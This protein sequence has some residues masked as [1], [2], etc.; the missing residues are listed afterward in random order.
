MWCRSIHGTRAHSTNPVSFDNECVVKLE[1]AYPTCCFTPCSFRSTVQCG[2]NFLLVCRRM[3]IGAD[4]GP[5]FTCCS[6]FGGNITHFLR[7][8]AQSTVQ[9]LLLNSNMHSYILFHPRCSEHACCSEH[10]LLMERRSCRSNVHVW[11]GLCHLWRK[12]HRTPS[13]LASEPPG[14]CV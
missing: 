14:P 3:N 8:Q 13:P 1:R 11:T 7:Q 5:F 4:C 2:S 12:T 6:T 10:V 9:Q